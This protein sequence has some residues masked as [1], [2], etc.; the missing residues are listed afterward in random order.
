MNPC[1]IC[2]MKIPWPQGG[3]IKVKALLNQ[4]YNRTRSTTRL[5]VRSN[6]KHNQIRSTNKSE[7]HLK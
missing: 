6:Q 5:D 3:E 4:K 1:H 2:D 7:V